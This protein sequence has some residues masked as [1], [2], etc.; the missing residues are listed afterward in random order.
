MRDLL[1]SLPVAV[2]AQ[3]IRDW[4]G[5][6]F[7][8][9]AVIE[10]TIEV[11]PEP[12]ELTGLATTVISLGSQVYNAVSRRYL[13]ESPGNFE[14]AKTRAGERAILIKSGGGRGQYLVRDEPGKEIGV[15]ER[16]FDS[17]K[18][19]TFFICAGLGASATLGCARY[20]AE[21]WR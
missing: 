19:Q 20:L 2:F 3:S 21:H 4:L 16:I 11:S 15:I 18:P 14:F 7:V 17:E 8:S 5:K 9:L 10:P 12:H 1:N 13:V 6:R